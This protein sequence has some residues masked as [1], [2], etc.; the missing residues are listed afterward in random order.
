MNP[1][2]D[3]LSEKRAAGGAGFLNQ[4]RQFMQTNGPE[5]F[6]K[7]VMGA[8]AA[9]AVGASV[10]GL[11]IGARQLY[12]AATKGRDFRK[13]IEF[14]PDLAEHHQRDPK[15]FN[16]LFSSLRSV[17]PAFSQD[18]VIAGTYMRRMVDSPAAG[19]VL[20]DA[21]SLRDKVNPSFGEGLE[22]HIMGGK[23]KK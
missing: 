5:L 3:F 6:G 21:V 7:A 16:Q 8:G 4:T 18:P 10:A 9:A 17:N 13:M 23:G 14:N 19:G 20:T 12:G 2:A 1:V 11:S 22:R 15:T